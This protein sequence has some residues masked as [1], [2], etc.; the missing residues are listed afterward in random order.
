MRNPIESLHW[1]AR[2]YGSQGLLNEPQLL[3][4]GPNRDWDQKYSR[5]FLTL[6]NA[7]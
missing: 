4:P 3:V 2:E 1:V 5:K 7:Q 6:V